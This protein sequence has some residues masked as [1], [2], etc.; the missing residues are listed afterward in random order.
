MGV[1]FGASF[2]DSI[3]GGGG[4]LM[5]PAFLTAGIPP[6]LTLGTNKLS[7]TMGVATAVRAYIKK[8]FFKPSLWVAATIAA[9]IGAAIGAIATHFISAKFL[10][11]F[12][13]AAVILVAIYAILPKKKNLKHN[14]HFYKPKKTSSTFM[15]SIIGFY[16]GFLGPGTGSFWTSALMY[17]YKMDMLAASGVARFMNF[18]S[19]VVALTTFCILGNVDYSLGLAVG[20]SMIVGS[21]LGA[22]SA[23]KYGSKFIKP[24]FV[25]VVILL[26]IHLIYLEWL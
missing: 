21:Y 25:T 9:L 5:V 22:H 10:Q 4:L 20:V 17:F 19:N 13:P 24:V 26:A 7:A 11:L 18:I 15:A 1:G 14:D 6:H 2:I 23:I 12:L 3:A 8:G 16:D